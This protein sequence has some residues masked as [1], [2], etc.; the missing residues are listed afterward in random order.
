MKK[1]WWNL[2]GTKTEE[3]RGYFDEVT[4]W[5]PSYG[6]NS[7]IYVSSQNSAM[8][9][10]T[11]F[12]CTSILSGSIASLPLLIKRNKNGYFSVD[13]DDPL[14]YILNKVANPRM[15]AYELIENAVVQMVNSGNAYILPK[16][17]AKG[18]PSQLI[19]LSP[20]SVS[21]D[22]SMD[23]Y[24]VTD[25]INNI[26]DTFYP[27]EIIHLKNLSL[28]GGYTG[29][30]TIRYAST[31]MSVG[32]SAEERTLSSFENGATMRGFVSGDNASVTGFSPI[33]DSQLSNVTNRIK[34]EMQSGETIFHLPGAMKFN[35]LSMSPAD[36]QLLET[37]KFN[38]LDICRFY[39]VHPD[40]AFAGQSQNYK[41]S[42]MSQVQYLTD[43]LQPILRKIESEFFAKLI[44][45]SL[46]NKY[47][48][49]FDLEAFFKTDLESMA[50]YMEKNIQY[51]IYTVNE[52][53]KKQGLPPID[54]GDE[55]MI[56]CNVAPINS[57][58]IRGE[59]KDL[60]KGEKVPPKAPIS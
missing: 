40:K 50:N 35:Q 39:G 37:K 46:A 54:G 22:L 12:R 42:E 53:R 15:T 41:A 32:A 38:V 23:R 5:F 57:E 14:D 24:M 45:R 17:D 1:K 18:D 36:I 6:N 58:K 26:Y 47:K 19:L 43:T 7:R 9:L 10:A 59:K 30:S 51:G 11:V 60:Q 49:E 4:E 13:K 2:W 21:Y 28:D 33:Q 55:A 56:S 34:K 25:S 48:I 44:P 52:W 16:Y 29:V 31:V 3:K 27:E 20:N 8:K